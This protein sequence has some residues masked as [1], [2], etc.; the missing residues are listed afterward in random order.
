[1]SQ[2]KKKFIKFG[3]GTDDVNS[4]VI[5]ANYTPSSYT[6]TQVASEGTDKISAHLKGI[7]N[8]I[9]AVSSETVSLIS[10]DITLAVNTI[11]LVDTSGGARSLTLPV[12]SANAKITVKDRTGNG[13][14]NNITIVRAASETIEGVASNYTMD[15]K[16]ISITL[17]CDGTNW[18]II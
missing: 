5:P 2:I 18:W 15:M 7:N 8:A 16:G 9:A 4:R 12:A 11:Y 1:M 6:P 3:T 10:T 17:V 14:V 13:A